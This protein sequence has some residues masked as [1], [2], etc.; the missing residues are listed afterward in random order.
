[1]FSGMT[2]GSLKVAVIAVAAAALIGG[3]YWGVGSRLGDDNCDKIG[4]NIV[5][6]ENAVPA[7]EGEVR[8]IGDC[9]KIIDVVVGDGDEAPEGGTVTVHY[10]GYLEDGTVFDSSVARRQP[11]A[12]SLNRVIQGWTKGIPGMRIG[13]QRRLII[14]PELAYGEAGSGAV[15]P[16]NATL[17]FDVELLEIFR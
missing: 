12:T 17:I 15:I 5:T 9:L 3:I 11:F 13:G 1:M 8:E 4:A 16:P 6:G 7:V 14:P 2:A 10:T